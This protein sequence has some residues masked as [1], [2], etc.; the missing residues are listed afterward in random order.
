MK[1]NK[2]LFKVS[3]ALI[4]LIFILLDI[5]RYYEINSSICIFTICVMLFYT[6]ILV[7][8]AGLIIS[9]REKSG[10]STTFA[11][12]GLIVLAVFAKPISKDLHGERKNYVVL[13]AEESSVIVQ[14]KTTQF[15]NT[16]NVY[17][18]GNGLI[19][20]KINE[21]IAL[22]NNYDPITSENYYLRDN[23]KT[24]IIK[25]KKGEDIDDYN[26]IEIRISD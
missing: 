25:V 3:A 23:D 6:A 22:P 4:I 5:N 12:A 11:I 9:S 24:L 1:I 14:L 8:V 16:C 17:K 19:M 20:K 7:S 21:P 18:S 26:E 2:I 15:S 13:S 10:L